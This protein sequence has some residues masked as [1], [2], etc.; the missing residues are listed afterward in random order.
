MG[1]KKS[2]LNK[3]LVQRAMLEA[4]YK[5][6]PKVML[7][8]PIMFVVEVGMVISLLLT[9]LPDLLGTEGSR[10]FNLTVTVILLITVW[11]ANFAEALA[12]GRGKHRPTA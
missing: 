1:Q 2:M 4:V 6:N 3:K 10:G 5:L 9:L 11:F 8:N 12:E 7:Q